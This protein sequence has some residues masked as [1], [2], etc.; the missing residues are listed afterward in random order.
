MIFEALVCGRPGRVVAVFA[1]FSKAGL[2]GSHGTW[3][4][5]GCGL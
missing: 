2:G 1:R 3:R 4:G 5:T